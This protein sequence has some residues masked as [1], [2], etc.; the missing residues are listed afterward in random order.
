MLILRCRPCTVI[1]TNPPFVAKIK[2]DGSFERLTRLILLLGKDCTVILRTGAA[3]NLS[4][5]SGSCHTSVK[6]RV[7]A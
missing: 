3:Q 1:G 4:D 7:P 6:V 2:P 5:P